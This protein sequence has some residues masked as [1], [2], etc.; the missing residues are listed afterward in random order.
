MNLL[1]IM[2]QVQ[3]R[4]L[5]PK[6]QCF[7]LAPGNTCFE[8]LCPPAVLYSERFEDV[9][10]CNQTLT[11]ELVPCAPLWSFTLHLLEFLLFPALAL[12]PIFHHRALQPSG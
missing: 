9:S 5:S 6:E 10:K 3:A 2:P 7:D 11:P 8:G 1:A 12:Q 4:G